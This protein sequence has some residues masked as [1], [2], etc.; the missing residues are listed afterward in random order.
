MPKIKKT[1]VEGFGM[2]CASNAWVAK[3]QT[4]EELQE[5][6]IDARTSG[7]TVGFRGAGASYGD[8][9][10]ST[11]RQL[12]DLTQMN[13]ILDWDAEKG[14]LRA[15]T[16]VT[17]G[18]IWKKTIVD[19]YWPAVVSGTMVPT[20]G[21]AISMNIHGKNCWQSG[22]IGEHVLSL[23]IVIPS[24]DLLCC[25]REENTELFHAVIGGFGM[26]GCITEVELQLKPVYSGM[27]EVRSHYVPSLQ[28]LFSCFE[29][30]LNKS[31]YV[32]GWID[33]FAKG[34]SLGRGLIHEARHLNAGEDPDPAQSLCVEAQTLSTRILG[35]F[36]K[37]WMWYLMRPF[38]NRPGMRLVNA[39][40]YL[41]GRI[42]DRGKPYLQSLVGFNF[43]LDY[44]PD[45][46]KIYLP[47]G[48]IQHQSFV[49][50]DAAPS[51][52]QQIIEITHKHKIPPFLAVFKR[53]RPDGFLLTHGLDGYSLALDFP[54][55]EDS[56]GRILEM[57]QEIDELICEVGGRFYPAKDATLSSESFKRSLPTEAIEQFLKLKTTVDPDDLMRTD[58]SDRLFRNGPHNPGIL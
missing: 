36:P 18:Q 49:P 17:I 28:T 51:T 9:A 50:R 37:R 43:L 5:L 54:I 45:W 32:V 11:D 21:G 24:G 56:R 25:S 41:L 23:K 48:F 3:V 35:V 10:L 2:A 39:V 42:L 57:T 52:I 14:I 34:I 6:F 8:A 4:P 26:L 7:L 40:K 1:R 30:A 55:N 46:K 38:A 15:E 22:P 44:V 29:G 27:V 20:I 33:G 58:L 53:H 31:D 19:G 16:G 12:C 47:G 13:N